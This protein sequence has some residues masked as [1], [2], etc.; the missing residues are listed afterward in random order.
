MLKLTRLIHFPRTSRPCCTGRSCSPARTATGH[1]R[2]AYLGRSPYPDPNLKG[3]IDD[4]RVYGRTPTAA[5]VTALA[6]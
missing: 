5:E 4:F 1:V 3:A 2:A 6:Q